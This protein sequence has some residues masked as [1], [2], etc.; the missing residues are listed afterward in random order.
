MV[1]MALDLPCPSCGE[2]MTP[3]HAHNTCRHCGYITPC[4]EGPEYVCG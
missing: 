1:R 3:E 4:C 2:Q